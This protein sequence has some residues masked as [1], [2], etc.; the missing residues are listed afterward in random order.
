MYAT[1]AYGVLD[2]ARETLRLSAAGHPPPF[3]LRPGDEATP[4][5]VDP[6]MC[7]IWDELGRIPCAEHALRPGDRLVFYTDGI[8]ERQAPAADVVR[9]IVAEVDR[10]AGGHEPEDDQ[11][12]LVAGFD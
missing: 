7:L 2:A 1:A 12:L 9:D 10:F 6:T 5:P 3:L 11:T 8:T 4:L